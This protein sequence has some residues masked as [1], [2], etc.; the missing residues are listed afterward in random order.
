MLLKRHHALYIHQRKT[1]G[2]SVG[3]ALGLTPKKKAWHVGNDG[4]L[5]P[6]FAELVAP[7]RLFVFACVRNPFDR[8]V[9]SWRYC[10]TT[11][12]RDLEDVLADPPREGHDFRH[13][14]RSQS[15]TLVDP[16]TGELVTD[17]LMRFETLQPDFDIAC[18]RIGV[19]RR[20]LPHVNATA[21]GRDYREYYTPTARRLV[22]ELFAE[23][24]ERFGYSFDDRD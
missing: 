6:D 23:D 3:T 8:V 15:A 5:D 2:M 9:S 24:L 18:D 11:R 16:V 10:R 13:F 7:G 4:V 12:D 19:K 20:A 21:R 1:A 14:T 17:L 22:E